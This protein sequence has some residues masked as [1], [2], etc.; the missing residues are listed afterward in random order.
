[1]HDNALERLREKYFHHHREGRHGEVTQTRSA[2]RLFAGDY[3]TSTT[4][5]QEFGGSR[6]G[7]GVMHDLGGE[8]VS[9]NGITWRVPVDGKPIEVGQDEGIAFGVAAHGGTEHKVSMSN[10]LDMDGILAAIDTYLEKTHVDHEQV[11]CAVEIEGTFTGV[12]VRT[13]APPTHDNETLAEVIDDES[14]FEFAT[15]SGA[16]VGFRFP[17]STEGETIPGLHLHAISTDAMSG[18]HV[19]NATTANVTAHIWVD[20]LHQIT[21][22]DDQKSGTDAPVDFSRLEG[23]VKN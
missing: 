3:S 5:G 10:G 14:R 11:V 8:V 4:V 9:R 22:A 15:W 18:G 20:D 7:L 19:R 16:L 23:E 2:G 21:E 12:L 17:D 13:V 6:L 1:M